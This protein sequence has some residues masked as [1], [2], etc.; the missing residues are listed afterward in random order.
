MVRKVVTHMKTPDEC[1]SVLCADALKVPWIQGCVSTMNH[2]IPRMEGIEAV[3]LRA[4]SLLIPSARGS[5]WR[6]SKR[7]RCYSL[8]RSNSTLKIE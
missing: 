2:S 1:A 7:C 5:R 8:E 6:L 4:A 3:L